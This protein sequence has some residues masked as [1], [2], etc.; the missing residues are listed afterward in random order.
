VNANGANLSGSGT[1]STTGDTLLLSGEGMPDS[2]AL[3]VQGMTGFA[4]GAGVVFG[5]GLR[6]IGSPILRLGLKANMGG[7]SQYPALG[8]PSVSVSGQ[9]TMPGVR[10]Y[11]IWYRNAAAF[12]TPATFNLTNGVEV[13]WTL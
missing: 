5:D 9:V 13:T 4:G 8:D 10:T 3:Y 12:C 2:S 6:C 11:Q 7:A 1:A